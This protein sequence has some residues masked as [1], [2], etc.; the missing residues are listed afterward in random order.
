MRRTLLALSLAL[1][2]TCAFAHDGDHDIS[3]VNGRVHAEAGQTYGDLDTVNGG[4]DIDAGAQARDASTVNGGIDIGN[5][6]RLRSATTV[7]GGIDAGEGVQISGEVETVNGGIKVGFHSDIAGDVTTVNGGVLVQ[8]TK[9]GGQVRT[10]NGD[11]TIGAESVVQG[12][13]KVEKPKG[14]NWGKQRTPR[15]VIGPR[16]VV[17]GE[18]VFEREVELFVHTTAKIGRVS[19]AVAK[20]Y[21]DSLPERE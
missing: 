7:N 11:I 14:M 6:A 4:I 3:R 2:T 20:P 18:L 12:G 17:N 8:Q 5:R 16:A 13:I 15:I 10:V 1:A 9:V 19:G 21:T